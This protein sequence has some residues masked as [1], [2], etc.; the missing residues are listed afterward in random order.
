MAANPQPESLHGIPMTEEAFE[1]LID[2]ESPYRYE[3]IDGIVYDMTGSSVEH[4]DIA[5]NIYTL[6]RQQLDKF[7]H[8]RVYQEQYV[9]IP[10][11]PSAIPDVVVTC[12]IADREKEKRAKPFK[13]QSPLI[14]VEVLS[15]STERYDWGGKFVKYQHC[16]TLQVYI[17]ASQDEEYVEVYRGATGWRQERFTLGQTIQL[18]QLN[19]ELPLDAIYKGVF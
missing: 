10:D 11:H 18:N 4:A 17:L 8:C 14:I 12:N 15:P 13:V 1:C 3:L 7:G 6:L 5:G 16:P 9:K 19:L 2:V